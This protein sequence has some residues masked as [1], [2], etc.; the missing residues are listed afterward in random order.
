M[1]QLAH[2]QLGNGQGLAQKRQRAALR[3]RAHLRPREQ[4]QRGVARA[5]LRR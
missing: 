2:L 5:G 1:A 3:R 4:E